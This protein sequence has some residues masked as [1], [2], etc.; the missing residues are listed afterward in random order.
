MCLGPVHQLALTQADQVVLV[1]VSVWVSW[2]ASAAA[3]VAAGYSTPVAGTVPA[4]LLAVELA[5]GPGHAE[6]LLAAVPAVPGLAAGPG[7]PG[8]A[9]E[10]AVQGHGQLQAAE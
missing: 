6:L 1:A 4:E 10:P 3:A 9:A 2:R 7:L 5:A 8:P